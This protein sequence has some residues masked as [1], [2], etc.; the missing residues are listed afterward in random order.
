AVLERDDDDAEDERDTRAIQDAAEEIAAGLVRPEP[1]RCVRRCETRG[2]VLRERVIRR[3]ERREDRAQREERD[4][5]ERED[6]ERLAKG[7]HANRGECATTRGGDGAISHGGSVGRAS[8][9]RRR[10]RGWRRDRRPRRA[11]SRRAPP[12]SRGLPR[13][14][15]RT[16][17]GLAS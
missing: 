4:D 9:R 13:M 17:R 11:A 7:R 5:R 8:N 1:M 15:S 3:D 6:R 14:R 10:R 12:E 16:G 2:E